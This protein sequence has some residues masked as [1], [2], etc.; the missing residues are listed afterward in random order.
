MPLFRDGSLSTF[1]GALDQFV[2]KTPYNTGGT[3]PATSLV[4]AEHINHYFDACI[5]IQQYL[6][7]KLGKNLATLDN[8]TQKAPNGYTYG[9]AKL[10]YTS[11][12]MT[13]SSASTLTITEQV[14]N[15]PA[16]F[17]TTPF[18]NRTFTIAPTLVIKDSLN[19]FSQGISY[20]DLSDQDYIS[21]LQSLP[22]FYVTIHPT[23]PTVNNQ[24][25]LRVYSS[26][27][28]TSNLKGLSQLISGLVTDNLENINTK[29]TQQTRF[30]EP[31]LW[32][33]PLLGNYVNKVQVISESAGA[34]YIRL[35]S[36]KLGQPVSSLL[37]S[38]VV[39]SN[40]CYVESKYKTKATGPVLAR[41][42]MGLF[43]NSNPASLTGWLLVF[44]DGTT[45]AALNTANVKLLEVQTLNL[46]NY[47]SS[48][49]IPAW[50]SGTVTVL[51][52]VSAVVGNNIRLS[53]DGTNLFVT[54]TTTS[55]VLFTTSTL[56]I[57]GTFT[58]GF[59]SKAEYNSTANTNQSNVY[60]DLQ[61]PFKTKG[62]TNVPTIKVNL[63]Y[64]QST[65]PA[66][67]TTVTI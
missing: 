47:T 16:S 34:K 5:R 40:N 45:G 63:M 65:N 10:A 50:G 43:Q 14:L 57:S 30:M 18:N 58:P 62:A 17:G 39:A 60:V 1:S 21:N 56:G 66:N 37:L 59:F 33:E 49:T 46:G 25:T 8:S 13:M 32:N 20:Y 64:V 6:K 29:A 11:H 48:A 12:T 31:F 44:E 15:V 27:A 36:N 61:T 9:S 24:F 3:S 7:T 4:K 51:S 19:L 54:D 22:Q 55:T 41:C 28:T 67:T 23:N 53:Y 38:K 42:G 26:E 2:I 35:Y 52:T